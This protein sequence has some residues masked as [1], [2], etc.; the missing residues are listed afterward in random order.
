MKTKVILT[1]IVALLV[2]SVPTFEYWLHNG[3]IDRLVR[4]E[5]VINKLTHEVGDCRI[6]KMRYKRPPKNKRVKVIAHKGGV[7]IRIGW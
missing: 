7:A 5:I 2:V 1:Y 3:A 4:Q 6:N